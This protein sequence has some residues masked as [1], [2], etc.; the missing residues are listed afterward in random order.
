MT[1]AEEQKEYKLGEILVKEG[2][3]PIDA[4]QRVLDIQRESN[5]ISSSARKYQPFGQIC[6]DLKL[7]TREELRTIL[8][9]H[10]KS[11]RLGDLLIKM[12]L[13]TEKDLE[14]ALKVQESKPG[15]R[16]GEIL[17]R[18]D[19]L[20]EVEL[21][22]AL[23]MQW[24]IPI[25]LPALELIDISL[26]E[27][28]DLKYMVESGFLPVS[29]TEDEVMVIMADPNDYN[30]INY[31]EMHY[32]KKVAR[33]IGPSSAMRQA[34]KSYY[35]DR[36]AR[37][38]KARQQAQ[39]TNQ[40]EVEDVADYNSSNF[41]GVSLYGGDEEEEA[42]EEAPKGPEVLEDTLIVGGVSLA[43][44]DADPA[45][46]QQQGMLNYLIKNALLDNATA[47]HIEPQGAFLRVRYRI[48]GVLTQKTSLPANLGNPMVA[49]LKQITALNPEAQDQPQ[50]N[51]VQ[52]SFNDQAMELSIATYPGVH[53]ETMVLTL[54]QKQNSARSTLMNLEQTGCSPLSLWRLKKALSKP[55]GLVFFSGPARSGKTTTA[56]AALNALNLLT[57]SIAT[58]ESPI[59]QTVNGITQGN[60]TPESG[61]TYPEM[62]RSMSYLDPDILMVSEVDSP[63]T[64]EATV[65]LA[66]GGAK[67]IT[68]FTSFDTMGTL[69]RLSSLGLNNFLIAS[70]NVTLVS[71]RLV[72]K[73]CPECKQED[74]PQADYLKFLGLANIEPEAAK[75]GIPRGCKTCNQ[76][77]YIGQTAI[78]EILII[79][80]AIRE[81]I[82]ENAPAAHIRNLART[83]GRL[84]SMAEDGYTKAVA[85][86]T[87]LAEVQRV[88]F[89]NEYDS[90]HARSAEDILAAC[91]AEDSEFL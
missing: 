31:L 78:H 24:D 68:S 43:S 54:R 53:G 30:L 75:V 17:L 52:A 10:K 26:L 85:G 66:L 11:I 63:E 86:L 12:R 90:Q 2:W 79:N 77:G 69:L 42:K 41:S 25:I 33:A 58:A 19:A 71:Q 45:H 87:T 16:L 46:K 48:D 88:A 38:E 72:R 76:L 37:L 35:L 49:R 4:V 5:Y 64:L 47:V 39:K 1:E 27:G 65:E 6:V 34:L 22:E 29:A 73:L 74:F 84:V 67:V 9:K 62:I 51:R 21:V 80:D 8:R 61:M 55:G 56:Y 18:Q 15:M 13:I 59:E 82:L 50:R 7:I 83:D 57:C 89:I 60:W 36:K 23:S 40:P 70:S 91:N 28:M 3:I 81:A 32:G 20:S 14:K 44:K